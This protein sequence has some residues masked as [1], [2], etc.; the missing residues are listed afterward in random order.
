MLKQ[1]L[2]FFGGTQE[3]MLSSAF[4]KFSPPHNTWTLLQALE[5]V[6]PPREL[7][8]MVAVRESFLFL[9]GGIDVAQD[10]IYQDGYIFTDNEWQ[11]LNITDNI[12]PR[13]KVRHASC[14]NRL[15]LFG[16]EGPSLDNS[17]LFNDLHEVLIDEIN[18]ELSFREI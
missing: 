5:V 9:Y 14:G 12:S 2:Y 1:E 3:A 13:V 16:G 7:A 18:L 17:L 8:L 11:V 15:L 4:F 6:P 10:T